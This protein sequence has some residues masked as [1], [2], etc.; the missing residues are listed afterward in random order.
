M[1]FSDGGDVDRAEGWTPLACAC[2]NGDVDVV[3]FALNHGSDQTGQTAL[4]IALRI[5]RE[6][7]HADIAQLLCEHGAGVP[8]EAGLTA[9]DAAAA[10]GGDDDDAPMPGGNDDAA[11]TSPGDVDAVPPP[12]EDEAP[13]AAPATTPDDA[14]PPATP[15]A[16]PA[17]PVRMRDKLTDRAALERRMAEDRWEVTEKAR[18]TPEGATKP[19]KHVD[20]YYHVPGDRRQRVRRADIAADEGGRLG[21]S[22]E[23]RDA[24]A[25]SIPQTSRGNAAAGT[26]IV[27]G[28]ERR[29]DDS[30]DKSP[31]PGRG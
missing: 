4:R 5:A 31:R 28:S 12:S 25:G 27:G 6:R 20:K 9:D 14:A 17:P 18:P 7:G 10:G 15:E 1:K 26:R 2:A 8:D 23:T 21:Y 22:A 19:C 13:D 3:R 24:A 30:A 29:W 11:A 16:A